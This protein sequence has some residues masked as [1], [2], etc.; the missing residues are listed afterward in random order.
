[1]RR[2]RTKQQEGPVVDSLADILLDMFS[3][4]QAQRLKDAYGK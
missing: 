2:L 3:G 4:L 1:M